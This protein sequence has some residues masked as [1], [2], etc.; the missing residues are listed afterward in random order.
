MAHYEEPPFTPV[1][2]PELY[3]K[4]PLILSTGRRSPVYFHAEHRNIPWLRDIDPDPVIEIHPDTAKPL[5]IGD[6]EWVWVEN[7]LGK[8]KFKAKVTIVVPPWMVM[9]THGWWFPE[10]PG[11]EPSLFGAWESNVNQLIPMGFQG[12][13]GLGAPIKHLLCRVY[14]VNMR[15]EVGN[16]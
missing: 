5:D 13:D 12:K 2:Q 1:S 10:K 6:G 8:C 15:E 4:Y 7:W 14:K 11:A 16:A 9:A 3:K